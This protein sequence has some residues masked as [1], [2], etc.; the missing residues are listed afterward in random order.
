MRFETKK[1][2]KKNM[3]A[4]AARADARLGGTKVSRDWAEVCDDVRQDATE[5]NAPNTKRTDG[6]Q[7]MQVWEGATWAGLGE[8]EVL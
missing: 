2:A 6:M 5:H 4:A 1:T 3:A 8:W 7:V